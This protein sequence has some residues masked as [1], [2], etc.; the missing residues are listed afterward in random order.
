MFA[1]AKHQAVT[2]LRMEHQKMNEDGDQLQH[3]KPE[4]M[5]CKY[6]RDSE[7]KGPDLRIHTKDQQN[8]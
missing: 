8:L 4:V 5:A 6:H 3:C 7:E 2:S 1:A